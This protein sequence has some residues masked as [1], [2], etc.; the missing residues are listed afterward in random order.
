MPAAPNSRDGSPAAGST[1]RASATPSEAESARDLLRQFYEAEL[2]PV[3]NF[4]SRLGA[5]AAH[6]DD[7][8]HDVFITAYQRLETYDRTRAARPWLL[9]IAVRR[10]WS[11]NQRA[12]LHR[13]VHDEA[14]WAQASGP[15]PH[16]AVAGREE[17]ALL[18][19]ALDTLDLEKR[20]VFVMHEIDDCSVPDIAEALGVPLN[21]VYSRLR[22]ARQLMEQA[23]R[24]LS[25]VAAGDE[26]AP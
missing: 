3:R 14:G 17:R 20:T 22:R 15:S 2:T 24:K 9:G 6:L 26:E 13:E 7:L 19:R 23:V 4:L 18:A 5:P 25:G 21:T 12:A 8:V 11:F 16:D 1:A 10:Y